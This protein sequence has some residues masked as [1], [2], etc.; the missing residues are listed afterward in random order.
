LR[1]ALVLTLALSLTACGQYLFRQSDRLQIVSP[2]VYSTV[3]EPLTVSWT[4]KDFSAPRDGSFALFI[5]RD[6]MPPGESLDYFARDDRDGIQVLD[7]TS[8]RLPVLAQQ[9]GV[10]PAERN[11]HD[12]TVVLLDRTG[13]RIGE[14]AGFTEFTVTRG[15]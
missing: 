9:V 11:H 12:V 13:H 6:P 5:D 2:R 3:R 14:Y 4:V 1:R 10:D 8:V 7:A 15:P